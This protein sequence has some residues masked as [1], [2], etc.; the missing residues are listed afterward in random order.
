MSGPIR[1][2]P[3]APYR[4]DQR[5]D[6][7]IVTR[8]EW[9]ELIRLAQACARDAEGGDADGGD[10]G[11]DEARLHL[12]TLSRSSIAADPAL[13]NHAGAATHDAATGVLRVLR[14]FARPETP[15]VMRQELA[16]L[17]VAGVAFL[18]RAMDRMAT[19]DFRAAHRNRPE[20]WG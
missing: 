13:F 14:A 15:D 1:T 7:R 18:D 8:A 4:R 16:G 10:L 5:R 2:G 20:V 11:G 17:I 6:A 12:M 3:R 9:R 19:D